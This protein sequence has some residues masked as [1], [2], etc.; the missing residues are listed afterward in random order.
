MAAIVKDRMRA[1]GHNQQNA[2]YKR[3]LEI[4]RTVDVGQQVLTPT[5]PLADARAWLVSMEGSML[6]A[7]Q[8]AALQV[9]QVDPETPMPLELVEQ[10]L[11]ALLV[12]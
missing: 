1:I 4:A 5:D 12:A 10:C 6:R 9:V 2:A 7:S 8:Q 3:S 11:P